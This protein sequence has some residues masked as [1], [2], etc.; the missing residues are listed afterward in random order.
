MML[1]VLWDDSPYHG[2]FVLLVE[3]LS[4]CALHVSVKEEFNLG[5]SAFGWPLEKHWAS[6]IVH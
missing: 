4:I 6:L 2:L 5:N 3:V 1:L